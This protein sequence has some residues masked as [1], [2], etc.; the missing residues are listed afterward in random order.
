MAIKTTTATTCVGRY[1]KVV[2]YFWIAIL[3]LSLFL[4]I[5]SLGSQWTMHRLNIQCQI[6]IRHRLSE[7]TIVST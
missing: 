3:T 2:H 4:N 1:Q 5:N 7:L 6:S